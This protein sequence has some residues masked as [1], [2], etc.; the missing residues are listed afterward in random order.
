[1]MSKLPHTMAGAVGDPLGAVVAANVGATVVTRVGA[2]VGA[3]VPAVTSMHCQ[4]SKTQR[5]PSAAT[6]S[7]SA[8]KK[9]HGTGAPASLQSW[10]SVLNLKIDV[11]RATPSEHHSASDRH[12]RN[13][14]H[15]SYITRRVRVV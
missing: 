13:R 11:N 7:G 15:I 12:G 1:M 3:R 9:A 6:Q 10:R 2:R 8:S 14:E 5:P 4:P